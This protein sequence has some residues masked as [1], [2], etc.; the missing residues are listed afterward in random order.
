MAGPAPRPR[1]RR[2]RDPIMRLAY[3]VGYWGLRAEALALRRPGRGVKCLLSRDGEILLVKHTYGER[4]AWRVPGGRRRPGEHPV[5]AA[6]REMREELSLEGASWRELSTL[7]LRLDGRNVSVA[8]LHADVGD[9]QLCF[10]AGEIADARFFAA[11]RLP[12]SLGDGELRVLGLLAL[13]FSAPS[14]ETFG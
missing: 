2:V 13:P 9:R 6:A 5:D 4:H 1:I 10:D 7:A 3:R 11:E 8:C 12:E 14:G